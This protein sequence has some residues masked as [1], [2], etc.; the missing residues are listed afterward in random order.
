MDAGEGLVQKAVALQMIGLEIGPAITA[1]LLGA[2]GYGTVLA[3][4][5]G[6]FLLSFAA[7]SIGVAQE[8]R[9]CRL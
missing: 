4:S 8:R 9:L 3:L 6:L 1:P 5:A 2:D 7:A